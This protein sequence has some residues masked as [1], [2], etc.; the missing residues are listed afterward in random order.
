[1]NCPECRAYFEPRRSDQAYCSAACN[2]AA[3]TRELA[4]ARRVYRA[5]YHWRLNRKGEAIGANLKFLCGEIAA[6][7]RED[8]EAQR[9]PPP[10]HDHASDRGHQRERRPV[11][12]VPRKRRSA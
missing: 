6:W 8:R 1:M 7:I 11:E 10:A 3:A 5:L 4:R 2:K 12:L 9:L